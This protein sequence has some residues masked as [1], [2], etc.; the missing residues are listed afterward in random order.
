[1]RIY[2]V[3]SY[4]NIHPIIRTRL[5][6]VLNPR[7]MAPIAATNIRSTPVQAQGHF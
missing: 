6:V 5:S 7:A 3:L 4:D 1:M 2:E